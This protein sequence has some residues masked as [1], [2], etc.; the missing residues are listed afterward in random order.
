MTQVFVAPDTLR[1]RATDVR[2]YKR[3]HEEVI[4]KLT[5]L[6]N[7]LNQTWQGDAQDALVSKFE[8]MQSTFVQF[9]RMMETYARKMEDY[10][11]TMEEA[12][13]LM[14][15]VDQAAIPNRMSADNSE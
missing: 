3:Q 4:K 1:G 6:V 14:S 11:N 10:A 5:T 13:R 15:Q 7:S 9:S 12:D 8:S 2:N